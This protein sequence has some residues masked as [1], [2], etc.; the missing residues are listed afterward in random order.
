MNNSLVIGAS[1][2]IAQALI[3]YLLDETTDNIFAVS[4]KEMPSNYTE[5]GERVNW[6]SCDYTEVQID[7]L[8][9]IFVSEKQT[10]DKVFNNISVVIIRT[11]ALGFNLISPVINPIDKFKNC[12]VNS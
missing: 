2:G 10:F 8:C 9:K 11:W 1:G 6:L 3:N 7:E 5:M 12:F 4:S